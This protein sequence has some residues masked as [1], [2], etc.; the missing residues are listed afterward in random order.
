M[1]EYRVDSLPEVPFD[2]GEMYSGLVPIDMKN[3]SRALFFVFQPKTEGP[4]VD[5]ITIW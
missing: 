2:I 1:V 4:P 3:A 5:E